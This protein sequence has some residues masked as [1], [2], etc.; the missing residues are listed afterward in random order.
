MRFAIPFILSTVA[1]GSI[2]Y[3]LGNLTPI[4]VPP[5]MVEK[6]KTPELLSAK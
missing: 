5:G 2:A 3:Y 6:Q 4:E 1:L